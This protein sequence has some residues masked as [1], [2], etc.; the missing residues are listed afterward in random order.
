MTQFHAMRPAVVITPSLDKNLWEFWSFRVNWWFYRDV[1]KNYRAA[2]QGPVWSVWERVDRPQP[3][4]PITCGM[5]R[6][7][8]RTV[9]I[10]IRGD[11]KHAGGIAE[12]RLSYAATA[13]F[14]ARPLVNVS[15]QSQSSMYKTIA[16]FYGLAPPVEV[17]ALIQ[18]DKKLPTAEYWSKPNTMRDYGIPS[19]HKHWMIPIPLDADGN[20]EVDVTAYPE[21]RA[22]LRIDTCQARVL[23][24]PSPLHH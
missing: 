3:S 6:V 8:E 17:P 10:G 23:Q 16:R 22:H 15:T 20:G 19:A 2:H 11:R 4:I 18:D 14:M 1:L 21:P 13:S 7:D 5:Q 12:A 24:P 9:R